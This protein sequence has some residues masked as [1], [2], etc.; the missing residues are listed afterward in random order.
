MSADGTSKG[1]HI[2][3]TGFGPFSGVEEN[4]TQAVAEALENAED[5]HIGTCSDYE[6]FSSAV[7]VSVEECGRVSMAMSKKAE[8]LSKATNV[9]LLHMGVDAQCDHLKLER[10]AHNVATFRVP[11]VRGAQLSGREILPGQPEKLQTSAEPSRRAGR[12]QLFPDEFTLKTAANSAAFA[13]YDHNT[14]H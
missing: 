2:L 8:E 4:P 13:A 14:D 9:L 7:E 3:L 12:R 5:K 10:T 1:V 6:V 11:D